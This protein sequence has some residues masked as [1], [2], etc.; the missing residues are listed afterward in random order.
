MV[1]NLE[2]L[3]DKYLFISVCMSAVFR[4]SDVEHL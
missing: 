4:I 3:P 2:L 1:A